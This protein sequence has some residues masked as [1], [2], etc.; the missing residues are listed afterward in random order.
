MINSAAHQFTLNDSADD[1]VNTE[2]TNNRTKKVKTP[3]ASPW[4]TQAHVIDID[5]SFKNAP[6]S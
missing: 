5:A 4:A 3:F 2:A 1:L 6:T